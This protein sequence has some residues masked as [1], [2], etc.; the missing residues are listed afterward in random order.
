MSFRRGGTLT[1][2]VITLAAAA[3]NWY[4]AVVRSDVDALWIGISLTVLGAVV[5]LIYTVMVLID[6][7][8]TCHLDTRAVTQQIA[9][10][11]RDGVS[12]QVGDAVNA[13]IARID[14][15]VDELTER[16]LEVSVQELPP[17]DVRPTLRIAKS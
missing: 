16:A 15:A 14:L 11:I 17:V 6:R 3:A 10:G 12:K 9:N 5:G 2:A 7:I 13:A 4:I 8:E 1:V